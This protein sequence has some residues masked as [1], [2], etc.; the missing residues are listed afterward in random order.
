MQTVGMVRVEETDEAPGDGSKNK[1]EGGHG[2]GDGVAE[3]Q[4]QEGREEGTSGTGNLVKDMDGSIHL[5]QLDHITSDNILGDDAADQ[6]D[7]TVADTDDGVDGE[8]EED[9]PVS[10]AL[11]LAIGDLAAGGDID[12]D[13]EGR[14]ETKAEDGAG[15]D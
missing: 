10:G 6:L 2:W 9:V 4:D 15:K 11:D 8:E 12:D 13:N 14:E 5:L 7:H 1:E 3:L